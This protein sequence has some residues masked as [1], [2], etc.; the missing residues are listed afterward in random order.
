MLDP[1]LFRTNL[2]E[3]ATQLAR[4]GLNIDKAAFSAL[5]NRR[6]EIQ[7]L[8]QELQNQRNTRSKSIGQA[9]ARGEDIQPLL[10]EVAHLGDDLKQNEQ[11]L[12]TIQVRLEEML[13]DIPNI[14]DAEV[15]D[16]MSE[17]SNVEVKRWGEPPKFDFAPKDHTELGAVLGMDFEAAAKL[18]GARFVV[19]QGP[20][21]CLQRA[22]TQFMLDVHSGVHGY[23]ETYVPFMVNADSMRGTGQLP[24]FEEDLF[25][26]VR[27]PPFYLIPTA[28][29]PVTNLVRDEILEKLPLKFVCHT[30]CFRSEAGSAGKD[31]KGMI[32]QHQF[33][34]V[35]LVRIERPE[36]S[37]AAHEELTRHAEI[38]LEKLGL[39]YRRMVLCAGDTGFSSAKT[40]DLEVWLPGQH[41]YREISSCSNFRDF[42][43]RRL[44]ARWRNPSTN[45]PELAHTL[46]GSGLAVGRTLIAVMENYQDEQ[47]RIRIPDVLAPYMGGM[48]VIG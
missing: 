28:E 6:K 22:L 35:E 34:K 18:T 2:D 39:P 8:T 12:E 13:L 42:Q 5:E 27:D 10:D 43:A 20:L 45:K 23:T 30:P 37:T 32:R 21:A 19:L 36:D 29:V 31:T 15:P 41:T 4:R 9:K 46:N 26:I 38:I 48:S 11:E 44:R 3:V 7:V 24:K 25:K 16:G 47:G 1:R 17:E 14:L 40:Y 33:E